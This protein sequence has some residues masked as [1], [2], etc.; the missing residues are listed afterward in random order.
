[1]RAK[2]SVHKLNFSYED[3]NRALK[4][5]SVPIHEHRVAAFIGPSGGGKSTL[6]R[7]FNRMYDLH[8]GQRVDGEVLLDG[9]NILTMGDDVERLR[10]RI[11]GA[12]SDVVLGQRRLRRRAV[13]ELVE[14]GVA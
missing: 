4:D 5:V 1:M 9:E 7:V 11:A 6:L 8:D 10:L 14:F 13:C 12:V 3:G 2:I